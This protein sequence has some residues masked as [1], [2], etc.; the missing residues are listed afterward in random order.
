MNVASQAQ[1]E[2]RT[3]RVIA[4]ACDMQGGRRRA[5]PPLAW[6]AHKLTFTRQALS[7]RLIYIASHTSGLQSHGPARHR[8][9]AAPA[10]ADC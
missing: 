7:A 6:L 3:V 10:V 4:P 5:P 2:A 1:R 9:A 8:A